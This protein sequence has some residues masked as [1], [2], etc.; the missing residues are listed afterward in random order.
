MRTLLPWN[1][2]VLAAVFHC[3]RGH[4]HVPPDGLAS[5]AARSA[6]RDR[7]DSAAAEG[8]RRSRSLKVQPASSGSDGLNSKTNGRRFAPAGLLIVAAVAM[9][10]S[11][12]N[13]DLKGR[14]IVAYDDG[15]TDWTTAD[16]GTVPPGRLPR[17]GLLPALVASLGGEFIRSRDL[18]D[19]DL[20]SADVL[21]VLPLPIGRQWRRRFPTISAA[22]FGGTSPPAAG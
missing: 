18:A 20:Q 10:F 14:R 19:A 15:A 11:P 22:G 6:Q 9:T 13:P 17:Y 5:D 21:I 2:P 16:P 3:R 12:V 8:K 4:R 1:L 7:R